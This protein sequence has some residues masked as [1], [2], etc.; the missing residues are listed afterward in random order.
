MNNAPHKPH[1]RHAAPSNTPPGVIALRLAAMLATA[2][3]IAAFVVTV[4]DAIPLPA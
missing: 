3:L 2:A 4:I 1:A